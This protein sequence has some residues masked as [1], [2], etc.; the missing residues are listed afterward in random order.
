MLEELMTSMTA[1]KLKELKKDPAKHEELVRLVVSALDMSTEL[2]K[3]SV[4]FRQAFARVHTEFFKYPEC[5][6]TIA[7]I[8][9]AAH[10]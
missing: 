4:E 1:D 9:K 8:K 10:G 5:Q 2:L 7:A 6:E 3:D